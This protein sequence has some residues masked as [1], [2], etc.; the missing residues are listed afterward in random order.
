MRAFIRANLCASGIAQSKRKPF[1][2]YDSRLP[3]FTLR[4]LGVPLNTVR[5]LLG[6]SSVA[7]SLRY[8]HLAPDQRKEAVAK[9]N[10]RPILAL[11][12]RLQWDGFPASHGY[13]FE[14][15]LEREGLE[16]P[17]QVLEITGYSVV[18]IV[19]PPPAIPPPHQRWPGPAGRRPSYQAQRA[20]RHARVPSTCLPVEH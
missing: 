20:K 3:G 17:S 11:T 2:I 5:D 8:A 1:E 15:R 13:P 19:Y 6:H 16:V 4:Q 14:L 18:P 10:E 7:M 9:L 12:V